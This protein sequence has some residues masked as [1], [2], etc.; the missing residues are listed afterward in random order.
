M[1]KRCEAPHRV[2]ACHRFTCGQLSIRC[3]A[4]RRAA[5]GTL[6]IVQCFHTVFQLDDNLSG[7]RRRCIVLWGHVA[8]RQEAR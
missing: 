5:E 4:Q 8:Q 1:R 3:R 2:H 7:R 6:Q